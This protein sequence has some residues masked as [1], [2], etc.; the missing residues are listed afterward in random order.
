MTHHVAATPFGQRAMSL[1]LIASQARI[2]Q[3]RAAMP[4]VTIHKWKV[5]AALTEARQRLGLPD[6]ALVVLDGRLPPAFAL[7]LAAQLP[8]LFARWQAETAR[9]RIDNE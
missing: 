9:K 8:A 3:A 7:S 5:F 2:R 4:E 1:G 6:R